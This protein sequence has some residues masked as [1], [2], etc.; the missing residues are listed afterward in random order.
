MH[1]NHTRTIIFIAAMMFLT[2]CAAPQRWYKGNTHTHTVLC[3]HAD[4][5]PEYVAQWYLDR[6]YNFLCLSEHNR[7][8]DPDDVELPA[9]RRDD[10]ILVPGEEVTSGSHAHTTALNTAGLVD[11]KLRETKDHTKT[12]T[13]QN[14][15]KGTERQHGHAILNHPN[16]NYMNDADDIRPVRGL[17]MF[18][19]Y[20]GHPS[21]NSFGD[22]DHQ[23]VEQLWDQLLTDGML[24]Y[25]V[26]SDDAHHFAKFSARSSNPGRGWVM[27]R[28]SELTPEAITEAMYHGDFYASS[29]VVLDEVQ[30]SAR[31]YHVHVDPDATATQLKSPY[32]IGHTVERGQ[33]GYTIQFIGPGGAVLAT[34]RGTGATLEADTSELAYVRA[35]I[36]YTR[37]RGDRY[38]NFYAWTQPVFN[39]G[40]AHDHLDLH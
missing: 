11:P 33:P 12:Q 8:I 36:T 2:G 37:A 40:R 23:S 3:G 1:S 10:F 27:V 26:S 31:R 25:G 19:L 39:D 5:T 9:D 16:F 28:A 4:S 22:A 30:I 17:H 32:V 7:Y 15:V 24:I 35:K 20:N 29:G 13:I 34:S 18:E 6:G 14:H 21:V 38:E